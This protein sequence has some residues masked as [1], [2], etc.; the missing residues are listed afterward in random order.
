[1]F[2]KRNVITLEPCEIVGW[3]FFDEYWCMGPSGHF[4]SG[5]GLGIRDI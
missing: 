1:M 4:H 3:I 5:M 2:G